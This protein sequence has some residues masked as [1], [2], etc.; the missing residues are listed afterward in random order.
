MSLTDEQ[1]RKIVEDTVKQISGSNSGA[2]TGSPSCWLCDD[3]ESAIQA[4]KAAQQQLMKLSLEER[5]RLIDAMRAAA[6][7]NVRYLSE[8]AHTETGYGK[9]EDKI[10]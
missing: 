6:R 3:A 1:I 2:S 4:A 10:K 7:E 8:L 9:V 5:G